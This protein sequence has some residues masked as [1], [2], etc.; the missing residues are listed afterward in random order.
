VEELNLALEEK[1]VIIVADYLLHVQEYM[2]GYG[3]QE[4]NATTQRDRD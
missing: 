1:F 4:N 3:T 2:S